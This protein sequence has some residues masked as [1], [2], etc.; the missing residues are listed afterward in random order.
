MSTMIFT[1]IRVEG[2]GRGVEWLVRFGDEK[3]RQSLVDGNSG[4][5]TALVQRDQA[6][7]CV[8]SVCRGRRGWKS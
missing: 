6:G 1:A 8:G 2:F 5:P 7:E 3:Q 4:G